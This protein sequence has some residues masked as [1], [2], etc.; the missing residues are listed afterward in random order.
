MAKPPNPDL[1]KL[2]VDQRKRL[3]LKQGDVARALGIRQGTYC[4]FERG[5][6]PLSAEKV[7]KV[8][9]HLR[10]SPDLLEQKVLRGVSSD[11]RDTRDILPIIKA[12]AMSKCDKVCIA[13]IVFLLSVQ[14]RLDK[15]MSAELVDSLMAHR[16]QG[17]GCH[18][19]TN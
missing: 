3:G 6:Q 15:S 1:R 18:G 7:R 17:A 4:K 2:V 19:V 5:S 12:V 8:A 9:E 11:E 14:D 16:Q 10:L 13:D